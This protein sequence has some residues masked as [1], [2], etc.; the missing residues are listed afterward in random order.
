MHS[1]N[2]LGRLLIASLLVSGLMSATVSVATARS[3]TEIQASG[4]MRIGVKDSVP[5]LGLRNE[6]DQLEGF[7]IDLAYELGQ[8]L[9]GSTAAIELVPLANAERLTA[10]IEDRVDLVIA[11]VGITPE[12]RRQVAFS[13]PYYFDGTA[14]AVSKTLGLESWSDLRHQSVAVLESSSAIPSLKTSIPSTKLVPVSSY[15]AGVDLLQSEAVD[16][17]AADQTI[18]AG[19]IQAH[20]D[21]QL[22]SPTFS[23]VGLA[24]VTSK[25]QESAELTRRVAQLVEQLRQSGW[26]QQQAQVWHLP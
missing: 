18:L 17:L 20:P 21:Y 12:R 25:D 11:Q 8:Q 7:E 1:Q 3:F 2:V 22:L 24:I 26:L 6:Q 9:L 4:Q 14:I 23:R 10:V 5:L 19:W 15:Q 16:G 13:P